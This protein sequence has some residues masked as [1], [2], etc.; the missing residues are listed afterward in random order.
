MRNV[1]PVRS[2]KSEYRQFAIPIVLRE[3]ELVKL[4]WA[5]ASASHRLT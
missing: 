3:H 2:G 5:T 1:T 4:Y